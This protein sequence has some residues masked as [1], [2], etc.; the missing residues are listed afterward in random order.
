MEDAFSN[1]D[2]CVALVVL[3]AMEYFAL[4]AEQLGWANG[5]IRRL[6]RLLGI[7]VGG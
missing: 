7:E 3:V 5:M 1:P 2:V 4:V 6:K